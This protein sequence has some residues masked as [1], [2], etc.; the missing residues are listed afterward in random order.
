M[1][2]K[3]IQGGVMRKMFGIGAVL[4][5]VAVSASVVPTEAGVSVQFSVGTHAGYVPFYDLEDDLDWDN[6]VVV[7]NDRVGFWVMAPSGRWVF[8]CRNMWYDYSCDEWRYGSWWYDYSLS[9]DPF[10]GVRFHIFMNRHYPRYHERYFYHDNG[11]YF[12]YNHRYN[13]Y[14]HG[15]GDRHSDYNAPPRI[16]RNEPA[17]HRE[18]QSVQQ[19]NPV[20][21]EVSRTTV[22]TREPTRPV[23]TDGG[24]RINRTSSG[25]SYGSQTQVVRERSATTARVQ[26]SSNGTRVTRTET[27]RE[28]Q[29]R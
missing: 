15:Q 5:L 4:V 29:R 13:N 14:R 27:R 8:R 26:P 17:I 28:M 19:V 2:F 10:Y 25:R 21:R 3:L 11:F 23:R 12:R 9:Y 20:Q 16:E 22:I 7:D 18:K 1:V 24:D 6:M